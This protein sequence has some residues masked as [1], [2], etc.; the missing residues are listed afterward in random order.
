MD[1]ARQVY[2]KRNF[3]AADFARIP[4]PVLIGSIQREA[5]PAHS[6]CFCGGARGRASMRA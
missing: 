3:I 5:G 2:K 4:R 1:Q 6:F